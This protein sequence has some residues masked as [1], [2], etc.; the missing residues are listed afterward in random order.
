LEETVLGY[1]D[2]A[3]RLEPA[4]SVMA[5]YI[6]TVSTPRSP[7]DAFAYMADLRNFAEWD[8]GVQAAVQVDGDGGGAG[9]SFDVTVDAPGKGLTLRYETIEYSAPTTVTV[10]AT[11]KM[12][13]SLDRIDV[14]PDGAGSIVRYD[15]QLLLNGPLRIFDVALRPIFGRIGGRANTG[16]LKALDGEQR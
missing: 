10:K 13:T 8:P 6:T 16:L 11:S 2:V 4:W 12:F 15:A 5:Q 7:A 3:R 14:T 1:Q 9:A